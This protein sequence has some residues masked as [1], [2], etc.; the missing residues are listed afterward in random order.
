MVDVEQEPTYVLFA[1][2]IALVYTIAF[3]KYTVCLGFAFF[4]PLRGK[5]KQNPI[6]MFFNCLFSL[7]GNAVYKQCR[8]PYRWAWNISVIVT[9]VDQISHGDQGRPRW[10]H[11]A[12]PLIE[13]LRTFCLWIDQTYVNKREAEMRGKG[14][15]ETLRRASLVALWYRG[16]LL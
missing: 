5:K 12:R 9:M 11:Y 6:S 4:F 10:D 1:T 7:N 13:L 15:C 3:E 14:S 8:S 2:E 16:H